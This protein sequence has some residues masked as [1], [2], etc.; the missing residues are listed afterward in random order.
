MRDSLQLG[1]LQVDE[2]ATGRHSWARHRNFK[3][4]NRCGH[5]SHRKF[6]AFY[7]LFRHTTYG[8]CVYISRLANGGED[9]IASYYPA[10]DIAGAH[11]GCLNLE[12]G[13]E[14]EAHGLV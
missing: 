5:E 4:S 11:P 13:P 12:A 3:Q 1:A 7:T 14:G 10:Q 2:E 9:E 8:L 6:T